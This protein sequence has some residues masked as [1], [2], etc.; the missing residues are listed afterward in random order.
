VRRLFATVK[1]F[2]FCR[3]GFMMA[4]VMMVVVMM[5][6]LMTMVSRCRGG[7]SWFG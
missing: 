1:H 3:R 4:M 6:V 7:V 5:V 2:V